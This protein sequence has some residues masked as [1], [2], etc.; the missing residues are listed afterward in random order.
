MMS[1]GGLPMPT[2]STPVATRPAPTLTDGREMPMYFEDEGLE[3]GESNIH[4]LTDEILHICVAM[5]LTREP[6]LQVFSNLN[7][8]YTDPRFPDLFPPPYVSPDLMVVRPAALLPEAV[9]S[10]HVGRDGPAPI[11][12]AEILSERSWQERDLSGKLD[13]YAMLGVREYLVIDVTGRF[14]GRRLLCM[15][16]ATDGTWTEH[17]DPDGGITSDLGFRLVVE[18][19]GHLRVIDASTGSRLAR[20]SE[21]MALQQRVRQLE[22]ELAR[23]RL[24]PPAQ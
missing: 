15:R 8:Y 10:Y 18:V 20:P 12:T 22:A 11:L 2:T 7:L 3:M 23:L 17:Q 13:I 6:D 14:L 5:L 24:S 16:L 1:S 4:V 21:A 9:A 19:D